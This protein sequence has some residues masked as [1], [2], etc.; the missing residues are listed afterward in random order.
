MGA[1]EAQEGIS[2]EISSFHVSPLK[3]EIIV[4]LETSNSL[5]NRVKDSPA[6]LSMRILLALSM[7][8]LTAG[9]FSCFN[10][11]S[12]NP[13]FETEGSIPILGYGSNPRPAF[14]WPADVNLF[15]ESLL[16]IFHAWHQGRESNP[17]P[18]VLE[19]A[20]Q[21]LHHPD[22]MR[23]TRD[24]VKS[25]ARTVTN[26][27]TCRRASNPHRPHAGGCSPS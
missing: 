23:H 19:T 4:D 16:N 7:D 15:P 6:S 12:I 26:R 11:V 21:S 10:P 9:F 3:R 5:L 13:A 25:L 1:W 2:G 22:V 20:V 27:P 14:I 18:S 24:A 17:C 8:N